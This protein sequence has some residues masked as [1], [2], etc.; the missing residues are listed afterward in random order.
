MELFKLDKLAEY[1]RR[2][3][4]NDVLEPGRRFCYHHEPVVCYS[5]CWPAN[6]WS[7]MR[8][9]QQ[10]MSA[11]LIQSVKTVRRAT[12]KSSWHVRRYS[13]VK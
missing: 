1:S 4:E 10:I 5:S 9:L 13:F 3:V 11:Y 6:M 7:G 8:L 12:C 2:I